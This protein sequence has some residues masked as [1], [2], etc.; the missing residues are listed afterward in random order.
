MS[1]EAIRAAIVAKLASIPGIGLVHG[2]ERFARSEKEFREIYSSDRQIR[3]WYVR[4]IKTS[5]VGRGAVH[6]D[7]HKFVIRGFMSIEDANASE[8]VLDGLIEAIRTAF[9]VDDSLGGLVRTCSSEEGAGVQVEDSGPVM[10]AG[11]LCHA[12]TL[13][14]TIH[15][16]G[17]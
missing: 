6:Q 17:D 11:V 3:G 1:L 2:Y 14:I 13:Q 7:A 8:L 10:F 4:R 9:R 5:S 12:A 16:I 15:T